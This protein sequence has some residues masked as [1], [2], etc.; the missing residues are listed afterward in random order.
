MAVSRMGAFARVVACAVRFGRLRRFCHFFMIKM[1]CS[2]RIMYV[3]SYRFDSNC[4]CLLCVLYLPGRHLRGHRVAHPA[5]QGQQGDQKG[6][7]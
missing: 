6:E 1:G 7:Q 4:R 2:R 3:E 5:A